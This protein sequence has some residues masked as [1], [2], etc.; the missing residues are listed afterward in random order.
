MVK[1]HLMKSPKSDKKYRIIINNVYGPSKSVDFGEK[2]AD[3][4]TK[5]KNP[6]RKADYLRRHKK[7]ED[8]SRKGMETA[9]F[10]SRWLLWNQP[11]LAG[12]IDDMRRR[13]KMYVKI[14]PMGSG[15]I[16]PKG[17]YEFATGK[18]KPYTPYTSH[19]QAEMKTD[20]PTPTSKPMKYVP[21]KRIPTKRIPDDSDTEE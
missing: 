6:E 16:L 10:W 3:D 8:W 15:G 17:A 11:T 19:T 5:H 4:Y 2:G 20:E 14:V 7:N 12:S 9:G 18:E 13:F 1:F 21:P